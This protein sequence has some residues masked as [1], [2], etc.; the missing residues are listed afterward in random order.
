[1]PRHP[2]RGHRGRGARRAAV[3]R[4]ALRRHHARGLPRPVS[5]TSCPAISCWSTSA[6]RSRRSIATR[7][8]AP[9]RCCSSSARPPRS[10][11][12]DEGTPR[13]KYL[14]EY[15]DPEV[16][17]ASLRRD[18]P[19]R[20][21]P[22]GDHGGVRRADPLDRALR[23]R[24]H[25]ARRR[26]SWCTAPAARSASP[27]L[28]TIDR[29]HAI[30]A[31]ARRDLHVVRRH[32]A[33]ARLARRSARRCARAAPTSASST[34]RSTRSRIAAANP[35]RRVV[36]FGHRLRDHR[37]R[38][39]DGADR[40]AQRRRRANFSMLASHVLVPPAI[41]S[42]P[43]GARQP[44]AG[45]PRARATSARSSAIARTRRSPRATACRS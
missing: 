38:Q 3:R 44:R 34:R 5:P 36:F 10:P 18:P 32:A 15:R 33:R 41:A 29:A 4:R 8:R 37:A 19:R 40:R 20:H 31:R 39:R 25:A 45:V 28:E 7:R 22:V 17:A 35:D 24:S 6:W 12:L 23:H 42:D 9:G 13:M 30:A 11:H 16:A 27:P 43:A 14:D 2:R 1:M 26:S 21:P